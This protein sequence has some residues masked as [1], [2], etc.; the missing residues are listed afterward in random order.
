MAQA[1]QFAIANNHEFLTAEHVLLYLIEDPI[2]NEVLKRLDVS[3]PQLRAEISQV[4]HN[5]VPQSDQAP[6][7]T[8]EIQSLINKAAQDV[9]AAGK[10]T[11]EPYHLL[12]AIFRALDSDHD[13]RFLLE[14]NGVNK[15]EVAQLLSHGNLGTSTGNNSP[16]TEEEVEGE[17]KKLP[18]YVINLNEKAQGNKID[19][20]IGR[21][22]EVERVIHTLVRRKKNNPLLV[23][24][25]G[26]GK[27]AIA[28]GLALKIVRGEV[29]DKL[30]GCEIYSLDVGMMLAGTKY[31]GDFE[32]RMKK[33]LKMLEN[34][35]QAI[36]F[37]DEI[38][39]IIGAGAVSGGGTDASNMLKPKLASGELK[40]I[41]STTYKEFRNVF[42][43]DTALARR[44]Q[45]VDVVEPS[46]EDTIKILTGVKGEFEK[47]H[48]V[49]YSD[50]AIKTAV[51]LSVKHINDRFLPDKA[52]DLLDEA[53]ATLSLQ[54][55]SGEVSSELIEKMVA[56][57]ARIPEKTVSTSQKDKLKNLET[58]IKMVL[59]GQ[60]D[61]VH[62][63]TSAIE[64]S[65]S[66]LRS[67]D[68]PI[69]S[70]LFCGPTGVGKTELAKQL[71]ANLG[72]QFLRF[73]MSEYAEKHTVS[74]LIGAPPG[75]VG[76][77]QEGQLTGAVMKHPHSVVLLDEIEKAHPEIFNI[78]LQVMDHGTLTDSN[79]R[80]ADF[81]NTVIILTS[82]VGAAE[83]SRA[84]LGIGGNNTSGFNYE[85]PLRAVERTFTPEFRNRLDGIIY[86]NPLSKDNVIAVLDK[87]IVELDN[88][89]LKKNA[90]IE[91][92]AAAKDWIITKGYI[93][94]MGARPMKRVL[95]DNVARKLAKELL[96]GQLEQGGSVVVDE[97]N[98]ELTFKYT[99]KSN[100]V[101]KT[102][103]SKKVNQDGPTDKT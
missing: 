102:K 68:R 91:F 87:Y 42:E 96:Y 77:D 60:D 82:N 75:Y 101:K 4:I 72:I 13:A 41:G 33:L 26:V 23:G 58:D 45:K 93:P 73:D 11:V 10:T 56:K 16:L 40:V 85:K 32:D 12:M 50:E 38:H 103:K 83:A 27:T 95:E 17:G 76:Y 59:Y 99:V 52:I 1:Q 92:T 22:L 88:M 97:K 24:E 34:K 94:A 43:K 65:Q 49:S 53:G 20:L 63:V 31:R 79:G 74:R 89:L 57:I 47:F 29:P 70:F 100:P 90:T 62:A 37:I 3:L 15:L 25:P 98:G 7:P 54:N 48:N 19:P 6:Q 39:T 55:Q 9:H 78:L 30:K 86:F 35:P 2:V 81:K 80:K 36:L 67:G 44:F 69:G 28:E 8:M 18:D 21:E 64:L 61:A 5:N 71:A 14:K 46:I 51:E 84:S 66:G